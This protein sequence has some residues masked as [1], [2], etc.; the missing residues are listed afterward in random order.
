[1]SKDTGRWNTVCVC[2]GTRERERERGRAHMCPHDTSTVGM[3]ERVDLCLG[4]N[5]D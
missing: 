1:M 3:G 4:D 5:S 2:A